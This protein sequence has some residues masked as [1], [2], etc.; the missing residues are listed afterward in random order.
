MKTIILDRDGV[1]NEDSALFIKNAS[2]WIPI[3]GSIEAIA[4][5]SKSNYNVA[6]CTNQSGLGRK[7][8]SLND[9]YQINEK[10]ELL[11]KSLGGKLAGIFYCPHTQEDNCDCRKPKTA[12]ILNIIKKFDIKDVSKLYMVGDSLRDLEAIDKIGGIPV[13]VKTGNGLKTIMNPSLP[14]KTIIYDN[15]YQFTKFLLKE[16]IYEKK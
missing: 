14:A 13:L 2:E 16:Q 10:M 11:I 1:I 12:M 5:L 4:L 15:L 8:F 6:I 3:P 9:F 7:L